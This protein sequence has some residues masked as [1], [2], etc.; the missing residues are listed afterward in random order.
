MRDFRNRLRT[1]TAVKNMVTEETTRVVHTSRVNVDLIDTVHA[2]AVDAAVVSIARSAAA[3]E[4]TAAATTVVVEAAAARAATTIGAEME[5]VIVGT[6][7]GALAAVTEITARG[8]ATAYHDLRPETAM[9]ATNPREHRVREEAKKPDRKASMMCGKDADHTT[10]ECGE[11]REFVANLRA[12]YGNEPK[13]P[14][15]INGY[16]QHSKVEAV[17]KMP[18]PPTHVAGLRR[19]LGMTDFSEA[20]LGAVLA[21]EDDEGR[22]YV[23][24]FANCTCP[25]AEPTYASYEAW[26]RRR[27]LLAAHEGAADGDLVAVTG[28]LSAGQRRGDPWMD[29]EAMAELYAGNINM[30]QPYARYTWRDNIRPAPVFPAHARAIFEQRTVD[31]SSPEGMWE[32]IT[33]H[34]ERLAIMVSTSMHNVEAAQRLLNNDFNPMY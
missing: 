24:E 11:L 29:P 27:M 2:E 1:H 23:V 26:A 16:A 32:L 7:R 34:A 19:F 14:Q 4:A 8:A 28:E 9:A 31:F 15:L 5:D 6:Q 25:C 10:Q 33:V 3:A 12:T 21:H 17:V 30:P 20:E 22:E 13:T 18:P